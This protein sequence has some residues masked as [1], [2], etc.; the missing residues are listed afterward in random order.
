MSVSGTLDETP[1]NM[2]A[3]KRNIPN[4]TFEI[5]RWAVRLG[6]PFI[7]LLWGLFG[8]YLFPKAAY[9][10]LVAIVLADFLCGI[11]LAFTHRRYFNNDMDGVIAVD[12]REPGRENYSLILNGPISNISRSRQVTFKVRNMK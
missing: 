1:Q 12:K 5:M 9:P 10:V 8:G 3:M 4:K 7:A 11:I 2:F 6:I